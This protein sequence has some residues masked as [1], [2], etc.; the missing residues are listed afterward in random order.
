MPV[1][2]DS[3]YSV[4]IADD[5]RDAADTLALFLR[6]RGYTVEVVYSGPAAVTA[7]LADP[8]HCAIID[9]GLPGLD[10]YAVAREL[11]GHPATALI[12]LVAHTGYAE[13][14]AARVTAAG[15]DWHAV[16]GRVDGT[17]IERVLAAFRGPIPDGEA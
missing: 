16:K 17:D 3:P 14:A 2:P 4:L 13:E 8:P 11:R 10:G 5:N 6:L 15:F 7:A 1:R 9:I 12:K